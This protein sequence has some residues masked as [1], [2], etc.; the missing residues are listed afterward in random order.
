MEHSIA[1]PTVRRNKRAHVLLF[2]SMSAVLLVGVLVG[3]LVGGPGTDTRSA[4]VSSEK[5]AW[6]S[7]DS[8]SPVSTPSL[9]PASPSTENDEMDELS[10]GESTEESSTLFSTSVGSKCKQDESMWSLDLITDEYPFETS[11]ALVRE[12]GIAPSRI[13][14]VG[15]P[16]GTYYE[17]HSHYSSSMCLT[18]GEYTFEMQDSE[19]D[20]LC[21][22]VGNGTFVVAIDDIYVVNSDASNASNF[23]KSSHRFRVG[24][25]QEEHVFLSSRPTALPSTSPS[26]KPTRSPTDSPTETLPTY[27]PSADPSSSVSTA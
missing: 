12:E 11:W 17:R 2:L 23:A 20:G 9:R 10:H 18:P 27:P 24:Q 21:C 15:P 4:N 3:A 26:N 19:G 5:H 13:L 1:A 7:S 22:D 8:T 25:S 14:A 16:V 6:T